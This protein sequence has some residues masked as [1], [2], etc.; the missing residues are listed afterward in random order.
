MEGLKYRVPHIP[1]PISYFN[2]HV[3][4]H[5]VLCVKKNTH[6][7]LK[8]RRYNLLYKYIYFFFYSCKEHDDICVRVYLYNVY[9][10]YNTLF[11]LLAN[12]DRCA[13]SHKMEEKSWEGHGDAVR[14]PGVTWRKS[15]SVCLC[16][17][18]HDYM[19]ED[20]REEIV[21]RDMLL[22]LKMSWTAFWRWE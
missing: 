2:Y 11:P 15:D 9:N 4:G 21:Y 18:W 19:S 10:I 6:T 5:P 12:K 16:E 1:F 3:L 20:V 7:L 22:H 8:G 17:W 13:R 14:A